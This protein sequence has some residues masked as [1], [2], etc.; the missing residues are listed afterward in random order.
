MDPEDCIVELNR[1]FTDIEETISNLEESRIDI[2]RVMT[3]NVM[4]SDA[5]T[6][7]VGTNPADCWYGKDCTHERC[8]FTHGKGNPSKDKGKG[9]GKGDSKGKGKE[10]HCTV[11][12]MAAL[13][14]VQ[15]RRHR[16]GIY[17][18]RGRLK[19]ASNNV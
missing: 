1:M 2:L 17:D 12:G 11:K 13:Q 14:F 6:T 7:K 4:A 15:A 19:E 18:P 8:T 5:K 9:K 16:K 10:L 3:I